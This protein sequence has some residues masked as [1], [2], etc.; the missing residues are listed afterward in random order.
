MNNLITG[1][2]NRLDIST[3]AAYQDVKYDLRARKTTTLKLYHRDDIHKSPVDRPVCFHMQ[4]A[5]MRHKKRQGVSKAQKNPTLSNRQTPSMH[6]RAD[7]IK[8]AMAKKRKVSHSN[9]TVS[10]KRRV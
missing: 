6:Q 1:K 4:T 3:Y 2:T 9:P 5:C 8:V 10:K 7:K